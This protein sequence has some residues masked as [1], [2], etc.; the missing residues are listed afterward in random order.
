MTAIKKKKSDLFSILRRSLLESSP[1]SVTFTAM[2]E[3][4]ETLLSTVLLVALGCA[5]GC[6]G[7]QGGIKMLA[8]VKS[9]GR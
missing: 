1:A 8:K 4:G 9:L 3:Y 5:F 6:S 2:R 7:S